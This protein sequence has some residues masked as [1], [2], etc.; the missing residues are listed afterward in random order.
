MVLALCWG[1]VHSEMANCMCNG[2]VK[3]ASGSGFAAEVHAKSC[4]RIVTVVSRWLWK[5]R[6]LEK[7]AH[8]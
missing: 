1:E 8:K 4:L 3:V 5:Q 6:F 2:G 7:S